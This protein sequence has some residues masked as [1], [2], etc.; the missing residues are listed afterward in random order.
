MFG[1]GKPVLVVV[2]NPEKA[3][4]AAL[5]NHVKDSSP[6]TT[7]LLSIEGEPKGNTKFGKFIAGLDKKSHQVFSFPD[8]K[9]EIPAFAMQFCMTEAKRMG[10]PMKEDLAAALVKTSGIDFGFLF[11]EL[12]KSVMHA[13]SRGSTTLEV[14]DVKAAMAPIGEVSFEGIKDALATRNRKAVAIALE[15]IHKLVKDPIMPLC[16]FLEAI[17]MGSKTEKEGKTSFGWLHLTSLVAQGRSPD[18]I[19]ETLGIH[20]YRCKSFLV[21]E[22]RAWNPDAVMELIRVTAQAR[23]AVVSGQLNPWL[24]FVSGMMNVCIVR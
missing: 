10:K 14:A 9:W 4:L 5:E 8:K 7:I 22:V 16:G 15:R 12:E 2:Y 1:D 3:P 6:A 13:E 21:P 23:R 19:A 11:F 24:I 20:P 17:A 18:Q